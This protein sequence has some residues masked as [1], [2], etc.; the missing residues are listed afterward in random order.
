MRQC[1]P[2]QK[3]SHV[4]TP[5]PVP[6]PEAQV[7]DFAGGEVRLMRQATPNLVIVPTV[8]LRRPAA[9][10]RRHTASDA[11]PVRRAW[12]AIGSRGR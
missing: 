1:L 10:L 9:Q 4:F 6:D 2:S 3:C 11:R 8:P 7:G 12:A 5:T